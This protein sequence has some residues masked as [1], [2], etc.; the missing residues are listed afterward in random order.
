MQLI[1]FRGGIH[2]L[3]QLTTYS[4]LLHV[5]Y[6]SEIYQSW[7]WHCCIN[8]WIN[9]ISSTQVCYFGVIPAIKVKSGLKNKSSTT[10]C[11]YA[12]E[13]PY[14]ISSLQVSA[15]W[16]TNLTRHSW[17]VGNIKMIIIAQMAWI[18]WYWWMW[19]WIASGNSNC[20]FFLDQV[21]FECHDSSLKLKWTQGSN[22]TTMFY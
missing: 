16:A 20:W 10:S 5:H 17:Q 21:S 12:V 1:F 19:G 6:L 18:L 11:K 15:C 3:W 22:N 4:L 9:I 2:V 8:S 13:M 14:I 7:L